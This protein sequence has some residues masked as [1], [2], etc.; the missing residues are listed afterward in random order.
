MEASTVINLSTDHLSKDEVN[1]LSRGLSFCPTARRPNEEKVLDDLEGYFR[2]L[3]LKEFFLDNEEQTDVEEQPHFR[4]PSTWTPPKG[5]DSERTYSNNQK[6]IN[7]N[8]VSITLR[9]MKGLPSA[10]F[11]N[12]GTWLLN[13]GTKDPQLLFSAKKITLMKLSGNSITTPTTLKM[14][15]HLIAVASSCNRVQSRD[16]VYFSLGHKI[17]FKRKGLARQ[18]KGNTRNKEQ[19]KYID[20]HLV[21]Y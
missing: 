6:L 15:Y 9:P 17:A 13:P 4:P 18:R 20:K 11:D 5:G 21:M 12:I 1:L 7:L 14:K 8:D 2:R 16:Q 10:N 3:R 19:T